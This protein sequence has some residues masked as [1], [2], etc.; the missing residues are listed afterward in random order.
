MNNPVYTQYVHCIIIATVVCV[1]VCVCVCMYV[2]IPFKNQLPDFH[3][4]LYGGYP[5]AVLNI[6]GC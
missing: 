1:C 6:P 5:N 3:R 2:L 4:T